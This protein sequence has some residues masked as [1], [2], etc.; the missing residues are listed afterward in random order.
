MILAE[1]CVN[2]HS[3]ESKPLKVYCDTDTLLHNIN[4]PPELFALGNLLEKHQKGK[5]VMYRSGVNLREV[6]NTKDQE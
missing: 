4:E 6:V 5:V 3:V 2:D 1:M